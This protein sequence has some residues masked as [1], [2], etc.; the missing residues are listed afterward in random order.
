[1]LAIDWVQSNTKPINTKVVNT[2]TRFILFSSQTTSL[3]ISGYCPK[4]RNTWFPLI[5]EERLKLIKKK[6]YFYY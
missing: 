1:M 6:R 3:N 2:S 4:P 5:N